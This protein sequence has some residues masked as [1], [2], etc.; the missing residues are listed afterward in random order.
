[1]K[2]QAHDLTTLPLGQKRKNGNIILTSTFILNPVWPGVSLIYPQWRVMALSVCFWGFWS[3]RSMQ[4]WARCRI[5]S[6]EVS[7]LTWY[8]KDIKKGDEK[9]KH[10]CVI[11]IKE[12]SAVQSER[13]NTNLIAG[14]V[15]SFSCQMHAVPKWLELLL[16]YLWEISTAL[17]F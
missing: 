3:E 16:L 2:M 10:A 1:M 6:G 5:S 12:R 9:R 13:G 4:R 11:K 7:L 15:L 8:Q 14:S 17:L